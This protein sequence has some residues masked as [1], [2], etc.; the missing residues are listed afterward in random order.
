MPLGRIT[1]GKYGALSIQNGTTAVA[2]PTA[3][4]GNSGAT[5]LDELAYGSYEVWSG[6]GAIDPGVHPTIVVAGTGYPDFY[7]A[8][9]DWVRNKFIFSPTLGATAT[10]N[11]SAYATPKMGIQA[12]IED[13]SIDTDFELADAHGQYEQWKRSTVGARSFQAQFN[14]KWNTRAYFA[15]SPV[16]GREAPIIFRLYPSRN[17]STEFYTGAGWLKWSGAAAKDKNI[18]QACTLIGDGPLIWSA[19]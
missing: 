11:I 9:I 10:V 15:Q 17:F 16:N 2:G 7:D 4:T 12:D 14:A 18:S 8:R 19:S 1:H 13:W 5:T 6:S 3:L